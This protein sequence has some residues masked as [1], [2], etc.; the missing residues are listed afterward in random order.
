MEKAHYKSDILVIGGGPAGNAAAISA[1]LHGHS[2]HLIERLSFPRERPGETLHPGMEPLFHQLGVLDEVK[3]HSLRHKGHQ[4]I[5]SCG[6][7]HFIPFGDDA[8]GPWEGFQIKRS[9]LDNILLEQVSKLGVTIH[10]PCTVNSFIEKNSKIIG[11]ISDK[12]EHR[13]KFI[14]DASGM[15]QFSYKRKHIEFDKNATR[16]MAYYAYHDFNSDQ[17]L[18]SLG[19]KF[20]KKGWSWTAKVEENLLHWTQL[21]IADGKQEHPLAPDLYKDYKMIGKIM[22]SNVTWRCLKNN[23]ATNLFPVGDAALLIDPSSSH[24]VLRAVMTGIMAADRIDKVLSSICLQDEAQSNYINWVREW[25]DAD[26]KVLR[27]AYKNAGLDV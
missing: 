17:T 11:V 15:N 26:T 25:Y 21:C 7:C 13:S 6:N 5:D 8:A 2:V 27:Q 16:M 24:G 18:N 9:K 20:T 1:S 3:I 14:I 4:M 23:K 10:Q 12:G 19:F 22:C